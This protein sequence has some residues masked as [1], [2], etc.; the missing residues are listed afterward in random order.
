MSEEADIDIDMDAELAGIQAHSAG[1]VPAISVETVAAPVDGEF[2]QVRTIELKGKSFRIADKVGLMPLLKFSAFSDLDVSDPRALGA[3][4]AMLRD[5]IH[6]GTPACGECANCKGGIERACREFDPGDW[7]AFEEHAMITRA[8][9]DD[10][11]D[12]IGKVMELISG[13]PPEPPS[14]SSNGR[15]RSRGGST[16]IS[17]GRRGRGSKR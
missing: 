14:T 9:A 3:M 10:L 1:V 5:C 2:T 7:P 17:S 16:A 11:L 8:D 13:R 4:Y 6:P 12:V 15:P